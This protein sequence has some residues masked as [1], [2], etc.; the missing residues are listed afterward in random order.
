LEPE[1]AK[2]QARLISNV[3]LCEIVDAPSL[4][5]G[6]GINST[7]WRNIPKNKNERYHFF[8]GV[9]QS[10]DAMNVGLPELC[11]DFKR[12][13]CVPP[14]E[15]Y[16]Q[17]EREIAARRTVLAS[18]YREHLGQRVCSFLGRI[19]LPRDYESMPEG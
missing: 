19:A 12:F 6:A 11:I 18:P 8:E 9:P 14:V 3:L 7:I 15:L 13:F 17:I 1:K 2:L 10:T 16:A 5:N 4:R